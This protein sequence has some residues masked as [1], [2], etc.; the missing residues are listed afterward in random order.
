MHAAVA[1]DDEWP[2]PR[3]RGLHFRKPEA[4]EIIAT[5]DSR[6]AAGAGSLYVCLIN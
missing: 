1:D 5:G 2:V 4:L 6:H 3:G